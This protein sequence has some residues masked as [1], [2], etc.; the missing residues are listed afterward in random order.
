MERVLSAVC[1]DSPGYGTRTSTVVKLYSNA[2]PELQERILQ[3]QGQVCT[4][5]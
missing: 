5:A 3:P 2:P 4:E 1:I